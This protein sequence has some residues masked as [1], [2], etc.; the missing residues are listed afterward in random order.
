MKENLDAQDMPLH[1]ESLPPLPE[2]LQPIAFPHPENPEGTEP[3]AEE[4]NSKKPK[5]TV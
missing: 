2:T 4:E 1:I 5:E 3:A